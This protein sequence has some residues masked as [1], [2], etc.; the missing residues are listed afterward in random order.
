MTM[1]TIKYYI[2]KVYGVEHIY[3]ADEKTA[4][5]MRALTGQKTVNTRHIEAL[6]ALGFEFERVEAPT[7]MT[8]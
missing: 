2:T 7:M 1:D 6:R 5:Y 3:I 4:E 8:V